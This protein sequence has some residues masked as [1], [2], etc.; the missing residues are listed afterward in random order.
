MRVTETAHWLEWQDWADPILRRPYEV[1]DGMLRIP[2]V[3]GVGLEWDEDAVEAH[4]ADL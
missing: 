4:R 1:R 2:D 3:P